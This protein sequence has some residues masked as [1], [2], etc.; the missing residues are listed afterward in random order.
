MSPEVCFRLK[1]KKK[2][3]ILSFI[4][5]FTTVKCLDYAHTDLDPAEALFVGEIIKKKVFV[6]KKMRISD[7]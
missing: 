1:K 2:K 6:T 3:L 4:T 5:L 7:L